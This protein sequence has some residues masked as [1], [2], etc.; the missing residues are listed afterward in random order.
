[1]RRLRKIVTVLIVVVAILMLVHY[2]LFKFYKPPRSENYGRVD[3]QLFVGDSLNQPLLVAFGGSQGGNTW[4]EDYWSEM[5]NRFLQQG[6]AVLSIGYFKTERTPE[7]LDRISLNAIYDTIKRT[8]HHPKIN[9]DKIALLGSSRGGELVLV[10]ASKYD[11]IDAVVALVPSHRVLPAGAITPNSS[12]WTF[13]D[14]EL[15]YL[16][17]PYRAALTFITSDSQRAW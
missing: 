15:P 14:Q 12:A 11:D 5:R 8:S 7:T 6:Y 1:M 13:D 9:P 10:L 4:S 2:L 17:I 3:A 16:P